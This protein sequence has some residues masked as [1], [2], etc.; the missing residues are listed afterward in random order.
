MHTVLNAEFFGQLFRFHSSI[1]TCHM[2]TTEAGKRPGPCWLPPGDAFEDQHLRD[3]LRSPDVQG[4]FIA[5]TLLC[6]SPL[7]PLK[8]GH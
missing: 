4:I 2:Q 8:T 5:W 1:D 7:M 3:C 6:S